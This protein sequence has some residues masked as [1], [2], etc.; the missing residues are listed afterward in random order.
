V[1]FKPTVAAKILGDAGN[2]F[3]QQAM[4]LP[5]RFSDLLS[6]QSRTLGFGYPSLANMVSS[7]RFAQCK[8]VVAVH[9]LYSK[10]A[11]RSSRKQKL[12]IGEERLD[13]C[14]ADSV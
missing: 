5:L 3:C 13:V 11:Y 7:A 6:D 8:C 9:A 14:C 1:A 12:P 4:H 10:P 2:N